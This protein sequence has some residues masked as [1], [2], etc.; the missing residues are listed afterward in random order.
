MSRRPGIGSNYLETHAEWHA[1]GFRP[2]TQVNGIIGRLP[3]YYKSKLFTKREL[4]HLS[5]DGIND[6]DDLYRK[7]ISELAQYSND[8]GMYYDDR[9]SHAHSNVHSKIS[10]NNTF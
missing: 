1:K 6:A 10:D 9:I 4:E 7:E 3:R 8:P 5:Y 2:Y